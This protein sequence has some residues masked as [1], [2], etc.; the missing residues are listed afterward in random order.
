[1]PVDKLLEGA[2]LG[3]CPYGMKRMTNMPTMIA[4]HEVC[5]GKL[6]LCFKQEGIHE[7]CLSLS[8]MVYDG[9]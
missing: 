7:N 8:N 2:D 3:Y 1:M 5:V 4:K 6:P 9:S